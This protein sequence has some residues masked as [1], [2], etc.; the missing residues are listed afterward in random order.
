M[1][2]V[3][4]CNLPSALFAELSGSAFTCCS[5]DQR[6]RSFCQKCRWQLQLNTHAP[7][8][9]SLADTEGTVLFVVVVVVV[10]FCAVFVVL[11]L[12]FDHCDA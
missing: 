3:F 8:L 2:S 10:V 12:F 6:S 1:F 11:F 9:C 5:G 7:Y 4:S